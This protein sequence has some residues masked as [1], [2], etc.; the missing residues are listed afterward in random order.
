MTE[1]NTHANA[2]Q[3]THTTHGAPRENDLLSFRIVT[4]AGDKGEVVKLVL[5]GDILGM[6]FEDD[7]SEADR[8]D[9]GSCVLVEDD[10]GNGNKGAVD[11]AALGGRPNARS[12]A[13]DPGA[14]PFSNDCS[15]NEA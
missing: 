10:G 15:I 12:T 3:H 5:V 14:S 8:V 11:T 6:G 13:V 4:R 9:F 7:V 1:I 2:H